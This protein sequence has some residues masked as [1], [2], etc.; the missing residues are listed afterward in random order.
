[1]KE[2]SVFHLRGKSGVTLSNNATPAMCC[3]LLIPI[4]AGNVQQF[5]CLLSPGCIYDWATMQRVFL[6]VNFFPF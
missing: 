3:S 5:P 6:L 1:M 4:K 2:L